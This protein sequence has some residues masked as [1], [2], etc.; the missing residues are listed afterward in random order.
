MDL[1]NSLRIFTVFCEAKDVMLRAWIKVSSLF[2]PHHMDGVDSEGGNALD[3]DS[4][5][6]LGESHLDW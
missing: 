5:V 4:A 1:S 2:Q 6:A 3:H